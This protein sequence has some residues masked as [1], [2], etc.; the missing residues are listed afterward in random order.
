MCI[1]CVVSCLL[2]NLKLMYVL[3]CCQKMPSWNELQI[4]QMNVYVLFECLANRAQARTAAGIQGAMELS[5]LLSVS[6]TSRKMVIVCLM[7]SGFLLCSQKVPSWNDMQI[8]QINAC[9]I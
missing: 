1:V 6:L 2:C 7:F 8:A 9:V 4:A 5:Q 3:M